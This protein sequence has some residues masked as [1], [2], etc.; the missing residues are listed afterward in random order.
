M[1]RRN[2]SD[3]AKFEKARCSPARLGGFL[4]RFDKTLPN[5]QPTGYI[6]ISER[7][8][9]ADLKKKA[10]QHPTPFS[11]PVFTVSQNG[12]VYGLCDT[13]RRSGGTVPANCR[14]HSA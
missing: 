13:L 10:R 5:E 4:H 2:I 14:P 6:T 9:A 7:V 1:L 11:F 8:I 12:L 3:D